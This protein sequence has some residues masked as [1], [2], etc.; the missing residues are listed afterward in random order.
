MPTDLPFSRR[1]FVLSAAAGA[2]ALL[3][4]RPLRAL[5][6]SGAGGTLRVGW[7]PPSR[8]ASSSFGA[9]LGVELGM[10]E[11]ARTAALFGYA[12]E[13]VNADS[14]SADSVRHLAARGAHVIL[15]ALHDGAMV[16]A[17]RAAEEVRVPLLN[18]AASGDDLRGSSCGRYT[19]HVAPSA[20]MLGDAAAGW[21]ASARPAPASPAEGTGSVHPA[22]WHPSLERFGADQLN[23]RFRLRFQ[24]AMDGPAWAGWAAVKIATEAAMHAGTLDAAG[25]AAY[26]ERPAT[27]FDAQKGWPLSFR[28]WDHQLR[29]PIYMVAEGLQSSDD[30]RVV[31]ELPAARAEGA[32]SR[33]ALDLLGTSAGTT[34]CTLGSVNRSVRV[35]ILLAGALLAGVP[36]AAQR[37][38]P[39]AELVFVSNEGSHDLSVIDARTRRVVATIPLGVRPRGVQASPDGRRIYVALSDDQPDVRTGGDAI[40]VVDV[41]TRRIVA[42]YRA[43]TDP[44]QFGVTPDGRYLYAANEDAGNCSVLDLRTGRE[45]A[46]LVVG[47]EPE[48]VGVSPDGRWVYVTAETSNSVSIID[49]RV[50]RVA[51]N[52]LVDAR[53]RAV[54]FSPDGSRAY[55]T[56]E[57]GGSVTAIDTRT[58]LIA[59]RGELEGGE[60]K[61]VGV[62]VSPDGRRLYV[63]NG[64][65][66]TVSVVD[67]RTLRQLARIPVGRRPWGVRLSRDG[68]R[69][70]VA[71]GLSDEL[72]IID[73]AAARVIATVKVGRRP[74]G[75]AVV[76]G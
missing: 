68:S 37:R 1:R 8:G 73:T 28:A 29:Q 52:L 47:I 22:A 36:A 66:G 4:G 40:A 54:A 45:V 67:A 20:A 10:E 16:D 60:G 71:N 64:R 42:R 56:A 51:A 72:S 25:I 21:L 61:P 38:Q 65:T 9:V 44:E 15:A 76:G 18:L 26:L 43:G 11:A 32:D 41:A 23:R 63:A 30:G 49:T 53:P 24:A 70:Y 50:N 19:F 13:R 62:A 14:S 33:A 59:G 2:G 74:W 27:E 6:G 31:G 17:M 69:L 5:A 58:H 7:I 3:S 35:S 34:T 46:A 12:V 48:G 39:R 55:V 75:I 57:I